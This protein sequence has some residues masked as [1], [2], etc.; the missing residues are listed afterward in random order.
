[1][2]KIALFRDDV[3]GIDETFQ[4]KRW[5]MLMPG[6]DFHRQEMTEI[7]EEAAVDPVP[8]STETNSADEGEVGE[9]PQN[10]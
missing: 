4:T 2:P 9:D 6:G 1:V 10:S 3:L 5:E 8:Q 7:G